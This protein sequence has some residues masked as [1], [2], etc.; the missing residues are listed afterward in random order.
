[1]A[2][3]LPDPQLAEPPDCAC[4]GLAPQMREHTLTHC[5]V[6]KT[7]EINVLMQCLTQD[8]GDAPT[9]PRS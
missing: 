8:D 5:S 4:K 7:E 1:M 6:L 3:P 9:R 2:E